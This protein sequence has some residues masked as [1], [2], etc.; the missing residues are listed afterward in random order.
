MPMGIIHDFRKP[1]PSPVK[2]KNPNPNLNIQ[3]ISFDSMEPNIFVVTRGGSMIAEDQE[4]HIKQLQVQPMTQNKVSFD[5]QK[6]RKH[7]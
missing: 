5:I 7:S 2:K 4:T 3:K 6:K 1:N